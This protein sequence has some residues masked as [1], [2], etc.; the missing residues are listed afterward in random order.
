VWKIIPEVLKAIV[1][2]G[3]NIFEGEGPHRESYKL[4]KP[5]TKICGGIELH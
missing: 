4:T 5:E 2:A 1:K 3:P